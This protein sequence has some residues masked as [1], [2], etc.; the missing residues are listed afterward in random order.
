LSGLSNIDINKG[1]DCNS[2]CWGESKLDVCGVCN[3]EGPIYECGCFGLPD[4]VC[5]CD[6]NSL[7]ECGVCGGVGLDTDKD[8][9]C[10]DV[11]ED[12]N[13]KNTLNQNNE[14]IE[15]NNYLLNDA[16][17]EVDL[18]ESNNDVPRDAVDLFSGSKSFDKETNTKML[19]NFIDN[20]LK[21]SYRVSVNQ[22]EIEFIQKDYSTKIN[23]PI[24]YSI[25]HDMFFNLISKI[26]KQI[27]EH[28]M[29]NRIFNRDI[30]F[31]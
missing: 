6:G 15:N 19:Y 18:F 31:C 2:D 17:V 30:Y 28:I 13:T 5:D 3:G 4:G 7:D 24:E 9:I 26:F 12:I 16:V 25:K 22:T 14:S 21:D 1:L 27:K 10:D 29:F 8:G 20:K 11:D 23:I